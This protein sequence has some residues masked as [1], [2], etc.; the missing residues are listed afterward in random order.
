[1][2][3]LEDSAGPTESRPLCWPGFFI[4][5]LGLLGVPIVATGAVVSGELIGF[6][7]LLSDDAVNG[8]MPK[9][10]L[11]GGD[12]DNLEIVMLGQIICFFFTLQ[13]PVSCH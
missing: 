5:S 7:L 9:E 13:T 4:F 12:C 8:I 10:S 6:F 11:I 2:L 3:K 1:M